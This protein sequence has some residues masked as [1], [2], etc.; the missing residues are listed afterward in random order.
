MKLMLVLVIR[1][2]IPNTTSNEHITNRPCHILA[3]NK[4]S[5]SCGSGEMVVT[6]A[7]VIA[8]AA[9]IDN[10]I[11]YRNEFT[12]PEQCGLGDPGVQQHGEREHNCDQITEPSLV[13]GSSVPNSRLS[14]AL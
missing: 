4:S 1:T 12:K 10:S 5:G 2:M 3:A 7:V 11:Y 6:R 13:G 9:T 8:A 14:P